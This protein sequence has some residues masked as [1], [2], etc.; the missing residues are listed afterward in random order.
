M[1][2]FTSGGR[3]GRKSR[4]AA[5]SYTELKN[6]MMRRQEQVQHLMNTREEL[7]AQ[8]REL[9][10]LIESAGG[11]EAIGATAMPMRRRG[12]GRPPGSGRGRAKMRGV[13]PRHGRTGGRGPNAASLVESLQAV[14]VGKTLGVSEAADAVQRAGYKTTSPNFRTIVNQALLANKAKFKKVARGQ[15]TAK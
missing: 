1:A 4:L 9:E 3:R 8:L 6:E 15:Y 13:A 14:L 12:P 11:G 5:A 7:A 2:T 10:T